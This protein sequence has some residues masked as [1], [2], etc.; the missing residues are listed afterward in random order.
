MEEA[1][2]MQDEPLEIWQ[3]KLEGTFETP[4]I[5]PQDQWALAICLRWSIRAILRGADGIYTPGLDVE[6]LQPIRRAFYV[7]FSFLDDGT[8]VSSSWLCDLTAILAVFGV[9]PQD[10]LTFAKRIMRS[11]Q[12]MAK[13]RRGRGP[14]FVEADLEK[15]I[16]NVVAPNVDD[17]EGVFFTMGEQHEPISG[18]ASQH[19]ISRLLERAEEGWDDLASP[20]LESCP[21]CLD[22]MAGC[23]LELLKMPCQHVFHSLCIVRWLE[24]TNSCPLCRCRL[25]DNNI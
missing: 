8:P 4:F 25:E 16:I 24:T 22:D 14:F 3:M 12:G 1:T 11:A 19:A 13:L 21:I 7:P 9:P 20:D 15:E 2:L 17:D 6:D 5:C 10:R 23:N 18:G